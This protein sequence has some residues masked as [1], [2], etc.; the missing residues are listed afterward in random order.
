MK[1]NTLDKE[2]ESKTNE[3]RECISSIRKFEMELQ[4]QQQRAIKLDGEINGLKQAKT[5]IQKDYAR[6]KT[7]DTQ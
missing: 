6:A 1:Y 7:D 2:I 3:L 5:L 4:N